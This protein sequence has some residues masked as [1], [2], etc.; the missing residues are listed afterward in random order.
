MAQQRYDVGDSI[1]VFVQFFNILSQK[2]APSEVLA[3]VKSPSGVTTAVAPED[4]HQD[5]SIDPDT[6]APYVGR[7][8]IDLVPTEGSNTAPYWVRFEG[9]GLVVAAEEQDVWVRVPNVTIP[10]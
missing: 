9:K 2:A 1:R 4:I 7:Y 5:G 10:S 8:Y 6:L 3:A